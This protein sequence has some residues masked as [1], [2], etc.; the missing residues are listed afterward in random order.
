MVAISELDT[1]EKLC[2]GDGRHCDL[3]VVVDDLVEGRSRKVGLGDPCQGAIGCNAALLADGAGQIVLL[4]RV[5]PRGS[6]TPGESG[7]SPTERPAKRGLSPELSP[8]PPTGF[9]PVLPP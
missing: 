7:H 2:D 4:G 9:E 1:D 3:V 6:P 8:A 5:A